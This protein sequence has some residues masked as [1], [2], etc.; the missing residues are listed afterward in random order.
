MAIS[1]QSPT[2]KKDGYCEIPAWKGK[3]FR[4]HENTWN[5]KKSLPERRNLIYNFDQIKKTVLDPDTV[6]RSTSNPKSLLFYL[7]CD[8][9]RI[10]RESTVPWSG[11]FVVVVRNESLVQTVYTT[12]KIKVGETIYERPKSHDADRS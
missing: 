11:Y 8:T 7:R 5:T 1:I 6:R 4:L 10:N 9:I 2:F 3:A 12:K